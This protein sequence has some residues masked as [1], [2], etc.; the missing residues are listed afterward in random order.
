MNFCTAQNHTLSSLFAS[1]VPALYLYL[2]SYNRMA[3]DLKVKLFL[4]GQPVKLVQVFLCR[5]QLQPL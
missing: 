4:L 3:G 1:D 5:I 2:G